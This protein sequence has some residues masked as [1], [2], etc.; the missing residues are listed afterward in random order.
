MQITSTPGGQPLLVRNHVVCIGPKSLYYILLAAN[1]PPNK[2][3]N[4]QGRQ[5]MTFVLERTNEREE[6][7]GEL[8]SLAAAR[9]KTIPYN[10]SRPMRGAAR[11]H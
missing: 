7:S 9:R 2:G 5:T 10:A 3:K 1:R 8:L 6:M 4:K 11:A